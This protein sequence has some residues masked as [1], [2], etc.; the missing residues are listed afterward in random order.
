MSYQVE[1]KD[2]KRVKAQVRVVKLKKRV[3]S[4]HLLYDLDTK[5]LLTQPIRI[6]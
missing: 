5:I 3:G 6:K 4:M 1:E 2:F